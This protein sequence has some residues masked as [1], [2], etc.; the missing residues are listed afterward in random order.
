ML[1]KMN[2]QHKKNKS[3][4]ASRSEHDTYFGIHHFAG[5]VYYDSKGTKAKSNP[6]GNAC[7]ELFSNVVFFSD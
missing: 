2:K 6:R 4:I 1:N 7:C 3:Y 5:V